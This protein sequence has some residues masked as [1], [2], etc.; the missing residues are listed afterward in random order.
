MD[1]AEA[2]NAYLASMGQPTFNYFGPHA[3]CTL[4]L[5]SPTWSVY[6]YRPSLGANL[7][8]SCIFCAALLAHL[9]IGVRRKTWTFLACMVCGCLDA[10]LGYAGRIWMFHDLWNFDAFI[11]QVVC[12][13][14]APVFYCAAIY[15]VSAKSIETFAPALSCFRP[16]LLYWIFIPSDVL[17]L[18][19]QGA[20]GAFSAMS[21]G[22]SNIGVNIVLAG[23]ALQAATL[24]LFCAICAKWVVRY[25]RS[26]LAK[27]QA[28]ASTRDGRTGMSFGTRLALFAAF[29]ALAAI[30]ILAR[31]AFRVGELRDGYAGP[32]V[33]QEDLFIGLE[34]VLIV[35]AA[36]ALCVGHPGLVFDAAHMEK[37]YAAASSVECRFEK[38]GVNAHFDLRGSRTGNQRLL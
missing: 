36:L 4:E 23:L 19:L 15:V 2:L 28:A 32:L 5:C 17:S 21:S 1:R 35:V 30:M 26:G 13:T 6:G 20:G 9:A 37:D 12:L 18:V 27:Q 3:N 29:E 7:A 14:T 38:Q 16:S 11:I 22:I 10:T 31:C 8:F 34:G 24:A 25:H 33:K